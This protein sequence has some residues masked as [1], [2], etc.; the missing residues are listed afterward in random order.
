[1]SEAYGSATS[2]ARW[3]RKKAARAIRVRFRSAYY[4]LCRR[5]YTQAMDFDV[6]DYGIDPFALHWI[7]PHDIRQTTGRPIHLP[8]EER[9][10][11]LGRVEGGDWDKSDT[12]RLIPWEPDKY[13]DNRWFIG[14]LNSKNFEDSCFFK[15]VEI[16]Y[17]EG[18][19][20]ESTR[21]FQQVVEG[22]EQ[23][24]PGFPTYG[25]DPEHFR[26]KLSELDELYESIRKYGVRPPEE[27]DSYPFLEAMANS[28]LVDVGR[29][30]TPYFAE[31]RRRLSIAKV[32]DVD[33]VPVRV[34]VRHR[35]WAEKVRDSEV[36][37]EPLGPPS[38]P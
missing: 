16:R 11:F 36:G 20:W 38:R 8:N 12:V 9:I 26:A 1:M 28:I 34:Q 30:G 3:K 32:L 19:R 7:S 35:L 5:F 31:G 25:K 15:A 27:A 10:P 37:L 6:D 24:R 13:G 21:F 4:P 33:V 23:G 2:Y 22:L 17:L 29:D 18:D 14:L